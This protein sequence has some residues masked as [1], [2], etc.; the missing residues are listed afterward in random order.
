MSEA[1][2]AALKQLDP[3]NDNQWTAEGLPRLDSVKFLSGEDS[4][5][6]E[7]VTAASPNFNRSNLT[8]N[9]A[10]PSE[11]HSNVP[12]GV[13]QPEEVAV[14]TP[15]A[16]DLGPSHKNLA[17]VREA[18]A[19]MQNKRAKIDSELLQAEQYEL[20]VASKI[21]QNTPPVPTTN[22]VKGYLEQQKA[23]LVAKAAQKAALRE[24]GVDMDEL[25]K[26]AGG[27]KSP[28]DTALGQRKRPGT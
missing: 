10:L 12:T 3:T 9:A 26:I 23:N 14:E 8:F 24:S 25:K 11:P 20:E 2:L 16:V 15:V 28:L 7:Q 22:A 13:M 19:E 18:I 6:R 4:V 1:I 21:D 5:T 27:L 17:E